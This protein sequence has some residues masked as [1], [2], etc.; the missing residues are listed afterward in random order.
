MRKHSDIINGP[1]KVCLIAYMIYFIL[2]FAAFLALTYYLD[3]HQ[4]SFMKSIA[5]DILL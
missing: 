5:D 1:T 3:T 2:R 4:M